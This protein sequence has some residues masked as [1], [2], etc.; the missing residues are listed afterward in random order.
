M[1]TAT[2]ASAMNGEKKTRAKKGEGPVSFKFVND[3]NEA[4]KRIPDVVD[5]VQV[6]NKAGKA[7]NYSVSNWP[8]NV[9]RQLAAASF[10]A[11]VNIAAT[12]AVKV[13]PGVDVLTLIDEIYNNVKSGKLYARG[14]GAKSPGRTFDSALWVGALMRASQIKA[15]KSGGKLKPWGKK[16]ETDL[17]AKLGAGSSE[18]R[19]KWTTKWMT[20]PVVK[21]A[22]MEIK[23]ERAKN[24]APSGDYDALSDVF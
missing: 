18:D 6:L 15:E 21:R 3:K 2:T 11:K 4:S 5:S 9:L 23:A 8:V 22:V 7:K 24:A 14:E 10:K 17:T 19:K 1:A 16:Q 13:N 12:N 20:D